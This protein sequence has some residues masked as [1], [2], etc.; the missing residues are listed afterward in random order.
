[1]AVA[2]AIRS[3]SHGAVSGPTGLEMLSMA[4]AGEGNRDNVASAIRDGFVM[5]AAAIAEGFGELAH[6]DR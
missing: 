2:E 1:M 3:I 5:V 4:L 6:R